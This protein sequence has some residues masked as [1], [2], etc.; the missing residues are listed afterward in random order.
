MILNYVKSEDIKF[1]ALEHHTVTLTI[2]ALLCYYSDSPDLF[3][4]FKTRDMCLCQV[5][6]NQHSTL[7]GSDNF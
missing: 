1:R 5:P 2:V 7:Y 3:V 4:A 6:G